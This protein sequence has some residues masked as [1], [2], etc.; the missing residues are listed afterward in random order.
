MQNKNEV[1]SFTYDEAVKILWAHS[2]L[3]VI[4]NDPIGTSL[5]DAIAG[6]FVKVR[7]GTA[8]VVEVPNIP[9]S[10]EFLARRILSQ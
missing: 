1:L 4:E 2:T 9:S 3:P 10:R 5:I 8:T 6:S 7:E